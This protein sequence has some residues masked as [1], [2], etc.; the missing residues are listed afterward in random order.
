MDHFLILRLELRL[1]LLW[2]IIDHPLVEDG[3]TMFDQSIPLLSASWIHMDHHRF[4]L[5]LFLSCRPHRTSLWSYRQAALNHLT[6][7]IASW[8]PR[9]H[10]FAFHL[11]VVSRTIGP[12]LHQQDHF[13]LDV[14]AH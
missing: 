10:G 14:V 5:D 1:F 11:P 3:L 4:D 9:A 8:G 7:N 6:Q 2:L 12:A 13:V